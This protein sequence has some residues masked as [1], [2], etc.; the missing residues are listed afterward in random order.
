MGIFLRLKYSFLLLLLPTN[1]TLQKNVRTFSSSPAE[2]SDTIITAV[3]DSILNEL[4]TLPSEDFREVGL[5]TSIGDGV[6]KVLGLTDVQA[7][8]QVRFESGVLELL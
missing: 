4:Q 5:V 2:V 3:T 6:A 8:E 1:S 7:G